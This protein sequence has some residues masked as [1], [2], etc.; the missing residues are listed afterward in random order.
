MLRR[1]AT[2]T[3]GRFIM[4]LSNVNVEN[5]YRIDVNML[6]GSVLVACYG[7]WWLDNADAREYSGVDS[8]PEWVQG[9]I[10]VLMTVDTDRKS[11]V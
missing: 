11:V 9:R 10:A 4:S 5:F 6:S 1:L 8:L 7:L 2:N 3:M